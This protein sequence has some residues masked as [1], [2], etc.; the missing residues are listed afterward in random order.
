MK[1]IYGFMS[2]IDSSSVTKNLDPIFTGIANRN[3]MSP[4]T[5]TTTTTTS[6]QNVMMTTAT[7]TD[8]H[9]LLSMKP[10]TKLS[11]NMKVKKEDMIPINNNAFLYRKK[12][13]MGSL[14]TRAVDT[15]PGNGS[16]KVKSRAVLDIIEAIDNAELT[17]EQKVLAVKTASVHPRLQKFFLSSQVIGDEDYEVMEHSLNRMR[18]IIQKALITEKTTGQA[19]DNK[20]I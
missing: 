10:Y 8:S 15:R 18:K 19:N 5:T 17:R 20:R 16:V 6:T 9:E 4:T 14:T 12:R 2:T 1:I 11:K 7:Q 3:F 13:M